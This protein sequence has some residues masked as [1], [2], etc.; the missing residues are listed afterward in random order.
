MEMA[1]RA[2]SNYYRKN[3]FLGN[4]NHVEYKENTLTNVKFKR[5]V[6]IFG[7]IVGLILS[8]P[9]IL[10]AMIAIRIESPG[11][12][13]FIQERVGVGGKVFNVF[14]LRSMRLDAESRGPKWADKNDPRVTRVGTFIRKTRIDELPQFINVIKGEMSLVGPRPE[15]P[16]FVKKFEKDITDFSQRLVVKPGLT[17][18][19]QINGGYD[20]PPNE[21][22]ALD[23]YYINNANLKFDFLIMVKTVKVILTG[24]GAR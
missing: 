10:I 17:G 22:L 9:F 8:V 14:K 15:R 11:S 20:I 24:D 1:I 3:Y 6:D 7:G 21:K 13:I 19:A 12:P 18:W 4:P 23:L 2:H 16:F 5:A